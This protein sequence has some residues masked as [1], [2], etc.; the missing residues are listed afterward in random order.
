MP[1]T[2]RAEDRVKRWL[3]TGFVGVLDRTFGRGDDF[4]AIWNIAR[5]RDRAW[6]TAQTL[7]TIQGVPFLKQQFLLGLGR[8]VG[9]AG[10]GLVIPTA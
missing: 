4:N 7:Q 6:T 10:R 5:A 3:A 1:T 2:V 9:F 8:M